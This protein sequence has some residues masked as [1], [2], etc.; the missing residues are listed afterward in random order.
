MLMWIDFQNRQLIMAWWISLRHCIGYKRTSKRLVVTIRAWHSRVMERA[1]LAFI[2][3]SHRK[4]SP[5]VF[6]FTK[7]FSCQVRFQ[8]IFYNGKRLTINLK[9]TGT[10]LAPWS[11]VGD[12]AYYAAIVA[13]H[14]NCSVELPHQA[15]M[16]CLRD[17]SLKSLLSTPIKAPEFH[18]AFG[19]SVDGVVIGK[20]ENFHWI[21]TKLI[22]LQNRY[23]R[24]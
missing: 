13:H 16:K 23:W 4:P 3:S 7:R 8:N 15:L 9:F 22:Y 1:Q 10:G 18:N 6:C 5:S 2:I 14:V 21:F 11:L 19:P 17:V 24:P 20:E 12:P